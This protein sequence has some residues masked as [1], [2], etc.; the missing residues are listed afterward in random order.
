MRYYLIRV[1]L[2]DR[3]GALGAV[4][5]R[6]GSVG[7]D[8]ISFEILERGGG[9]VVDEF[10]VHVAGEGPIDL[11][12]EEILEVDG[13]SVES[14]RPVEGELPGRNAEMLDVT[15]DLFRQHSPAVLLERLTERVRASLAADFVAVV[16][17]G[18]FGVVAG[19]GGLPVGDRLEALARPAEGTR[20]PVAVDPVSTTAVMLQ[21]GLVL[22]VGRR[23]PVLRDRER[24]WVSVM[25]DIADHG[26]RD[27]AGPEG[28]G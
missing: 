7:G 22:V 18:S 4:A 24:Q 6:I 23:H 9:V 11:L 8:V 1:H 21:A 15:A 5:S 12:R 28:A 13:V 16:D 26:W 19:E 14:L 27:L 20:T 2:P 25:A 17:A 10:G 3:P